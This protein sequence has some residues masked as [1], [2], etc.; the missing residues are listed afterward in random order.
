MLEI[1]VKY[2]VEDFAEVEVRLRSLGL[3]DPRERR[4]VDR[5]FNAPDR[6]FAQTDEALRL[7]CIANSNRLTYKGPKLDKV[8]KTRVEI[9]APLAD[10][11]DAAATF[12]QLLVALG[13]R[14]VATVAKRRQ[15]YHT[16][17]AGFAVE[18]CLDHVDDLGC[19][20]EVEI[21]AP[22]EKM[23]NAKAV[24]QEMAAELGLRN[25]ERRSYL[26]M[27]L[28]KRAEDQRAHM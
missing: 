21:V 7:R 25:S 15:V 14:E 16:H 12:A 26:T 23:E 27:L 6:D 19:F 10:G 2:R 28:A 11:A 9:E 5:Y 1:E 18:I 20:A 17:R 22:E 4:D 24:V 8:T 13:Y 3:T